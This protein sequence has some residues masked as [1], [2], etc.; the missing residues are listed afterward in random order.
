MVPSN[1]LCAQNTCPV[2][3]QAQRIKPHAWPHQRQAT[4]ARFSPRYS[5]CFCSCQTVRRRTETFCTTTRPSGPAPLALLF[6]SPPSLAFDDC[7]TSRYRRLPNVPL[8]T[9]AYVSPPTTVPCLAT[10]TATRLAI[11]NRPSSRLPSLLRLLA[12][13]GCLCRQHVG[14]NADETQGQCVAIFNILVSAFAW[15]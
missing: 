13:L 3:P 12:R 10:M 9:S 8:P 4:V 1:S 2:P 15:R 7:L 14:L 11:A 5:A 6:L